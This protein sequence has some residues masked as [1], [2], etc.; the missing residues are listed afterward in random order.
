MTKANDRLFLDTGY[1]F[2]R[3]NPRDQFHAVAVQLDEVV[4]S[5]QEIWTTDAVLLE[6]CA[7]FSSPKERETAVVLW[8]QFKSR[9]SRYRLVN[10][11][12]SNLETAMSLFRSRMD[13]SWS[14]ADCLSFV[15][16][17][18]QGL[19][20]ALTADHHF[21]QAGFRAMLIED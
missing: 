19:T 1:A 11:G 17:D 6:I 3:F 5:C 9:D 20:D 13:K 4:N 15:A 16:M 12:S 10:A 18:Q 2:A 7:G 14:L 21:V 8:D